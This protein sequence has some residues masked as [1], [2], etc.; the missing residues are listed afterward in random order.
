MGKKQRELI[1][2]VRLCYYCRTYRAEYFEI[3]Q[4]FKGSV[5]LTV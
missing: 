1:L 2:H 4:A 5:L 3:I